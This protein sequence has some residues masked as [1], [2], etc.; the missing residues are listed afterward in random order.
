MKTFLY[1]LLFAFIIGIA[2]LGYTF[3]PNDLT[4]TSSPAHKLPD[5]DIPDGVK[6]RAI[7]TGT[8]SSVAGF[9]YRGGSFL[10]PR[11]TI[12]GSILI[13]HPKG[14][15]LIDAGFGSNIEQHKRAMH[16]LMKGLAKLETGKTVKE[17]LQ[18]AGID[19]NNIKGVLLTHSHWDHTSG[20]EDLKNI[21]VLLPKKE[22][23]FMATGK[24]ISSV[25]RRTITEN[26]RIYEF[27]SG[28]YMGFQE[29]HD[30]YDDGSIVVVPAPGHTPGS[31]IIFVNTSMG[32]RYVFIG[33]LAW[34]L[35]GIQRP[36]ERPWLSR[37]LV[38]DQPKK[39]RNLL[40]KMHRISKNNP[41]LIITPVHD[42]R[43]W[44]QL[45]KL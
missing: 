6:I 27:N 36:A 24:I 8:I 18:G 5:T 15:L 42:A 3:L 33:D 43:V 13:D 22:L 26:H 40:V 34:Q 28:S 20:L 39:I 44:S 29:S 35:E 21:P 14:M 12:V 10:K 4:I 2:V 30:F 1:V 37:Y 41:E 11:T 38:D 32:K 23:D 7:N 31:V 16:W 45:P 9:A 17:Q 19:E 25:A